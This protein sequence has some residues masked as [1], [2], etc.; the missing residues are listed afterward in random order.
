MDHKKADEFEKL[1]KKRATLVVIDGKLGR[2]G[3]LGKNKKY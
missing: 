3:I 1:H 2:R